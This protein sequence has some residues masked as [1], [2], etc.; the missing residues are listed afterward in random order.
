MA[1]TAESVREELAKILQP[2]DPDA[3]PTVLGAGN[4]DLEAGRVYLGALAPG[5]W[6]VAAWPEEF[7]GRG[8]TNEEAA[9]IARVLTAFAAPDLYPYLVGLALVGPTLLEHG[10]PEQC[11]RFLPTL[12]TGEEIWCQLFSEPEAGSD[13]AN[14]ATR[15]TQDGDVWRITGSKVWSSRAHYSHWG[16][17][18][19][20]TEPDAPKHAGITA[21]A[22]DMR[23]PW[24]P[25]RPG[26][27]RHSAP[28]GP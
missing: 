17:L 22:V 10:T 7:G 26:R 24:R 19:A 15:A 13:L 27:V 21:F 4:D 18:L 2:R 25:I 11:R 16:W 23:A 3:P 12:A 9:L 1:L 6:H 20:R 28:A 5:G 14:L 8:A